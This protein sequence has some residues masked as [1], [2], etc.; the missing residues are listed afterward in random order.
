MFAQFQKWTQRK[1]S[2]HQWV[3]P[4]GT[5]LHWLPYHPF[6]MEPVYKLFGLFWWHFQSYIMVWKESLA[7]FA[8]QAS[9]KL[10][11]QKFDRWVIGYERSRHIH[12]TNILHICT[13]FV[14]IRSEYCKSL[15]FS[16]YLIL[17]FWGS[18]AKIK[19]AIIWYLL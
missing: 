18:L 8:I 1:Q 17:A 9:H 10:S 7:C 19:F 3:S 11:L 5:L 12:T 4:K 2:F 13:L 14:S 16:E 15:I 6:E